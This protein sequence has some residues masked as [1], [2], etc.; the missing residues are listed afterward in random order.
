MNPIQRIRI[1][2]DAYKTPGSPLSKA[3]CLAEI[4]SIVADV[5]RIDHLTAVDD[6]LKVDIL[7]A[8]IVNI[9]RLLPDR[10]SI[11]FTR[12]DAV[13]MLKQVFPDGESQDCIFTG[14]TPIYAVPVVPALRKLPEDLQHG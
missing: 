6:R 8:S 3:A 4:E 12:L 9:G 13:T 1:V 10:M 2:L 7:R 5:E 11:A 14:H